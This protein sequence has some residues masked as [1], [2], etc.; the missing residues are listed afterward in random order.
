[1]S[2]NLCV[3]NEAH[4]IVSHYGKRIFSLKFQTA[5]WSEQCGHAHKRPTHRLS[6]F[7]GMNN[8]L[9]VVCCCLSCAC[10]CVCGK[11]GHK[12]LETKK[13]IAYFAARAL[14]QAW[15]ACGGALVCVCVCACVTVNCLSVGNM[16]TCIYLCLLIFSSFSL[17]SPLSLLCFLP[18][19]ICTHL[20][21]AGEQSA[22]SFE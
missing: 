7:L 17:P 13:N 21:H 19:H 3:T 16:L 6:T 12:K 11:F 9:C 4:S 15:P 22:I 18:G 1:M 10:V 8:Y 20:P 2:G 14:A 5:S